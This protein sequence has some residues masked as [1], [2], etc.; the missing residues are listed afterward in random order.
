MGSLS[1]IFA[2]SW[3]AID[4]PS[5]QYLVEGVVHAVITPLPSVRGPRLDRLNTILPPRFRLR[6]MHGDETGEYE[7]TQ[8]ELVA[9][10][11]T[12]RPPIPTQRGWSTVGSVLDQ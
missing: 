7:G 4:S 3:H 1:A 2:D 10:L 11:A 6:V 5:A 12:L 9:R 8:Q